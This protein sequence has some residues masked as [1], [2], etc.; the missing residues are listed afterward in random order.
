MDGV[1]E[2]GD[3]SEDDDDGAAAADGGEGGEAGGGA[4]RLL[5]GWARAHERNPDKPKKEKRAPTK[6][7]ASISALDADEKFNFQMNKGIR[8]A[9]KAQKKQTAK[10]NAA[11][12]ML[13]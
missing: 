6:R 1:V 2:P 7:A 9:Q 10:L 13:R 11:R 12:M 5:Q 4:P 8:K 3:E